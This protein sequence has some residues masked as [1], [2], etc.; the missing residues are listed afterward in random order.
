[1]KPVKREEMGQV[2]GRIL[3]ET[4][5]TD[6][7]THIYPAAFGDL[8]L[9]GVDE[10]ITYHYLIAETFRYE[11]SSYEQYFSMPKRQQAD[12][13]WKT[14]FLDR[15]PLSEAQRG[16]LTVMNKLGQDVRSRDLGAIR[17]YCE[18]KSVD[19]YIDI[20][21]KTA[22]VKEV[23]MTNDI[24]NPQ[25][26]A[27]WSAGPKLDPRF[28]AVLRIDPL[29]NL[30][31]SAIDLL[32]KTGYNADAELGGDS[33]AEIRRFLKDWML[34]MDALYVA[35]S[36]PPTFR[37]PEGSLRSR[38]VEECVLPVCRELNRPFAMMIGVTKRV[39][40]G[41]GDAGDAVS[42]ADIGTVTYLC[43]KYPANK[44]LVTM[45]ALENQHELAVTARKF[46]NLMVFGCWWFLN[47]PSIIDR[48]TRMRFELLGLS[49]IPQHSDAR[50]LDQ[51][52]Y[53]W[54]HSRRLI[55]GILA[56]KYLDVMETGW[57][58]TEEE[59]RKDVADLF[60][61]NFWR[62]LDRK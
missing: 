44:F 38:V 58:F 16:V 43:Q 13:I 47:N 61:N 46:N 11:K 10:L 37:V 26:F 60:S 54:D 45:L 15:S 18:S 53:K 40:P 27:V 59:I 32:Q 2:V 17:E 57:E 34:K 12:L 35:A 24:F 39:N 31:A 6:V 49:F 50:V 21:F 30:D 7:H 19:E 42:K 48:M 56:E 22:G 9:W 4:P 25:E 28:K 33:V 52:I 1:M 51:L 62:F 55:G 8:L 3:R 29:L 36:L 20:V 23:V 41:L 14:L 5:I